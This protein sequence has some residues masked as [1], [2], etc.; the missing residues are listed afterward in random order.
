MTY[1]SVIL[2]FQLQLGTVYVRYHWYATHAPPLGTKVAV[3]ATLALSGGARVAHFTVLFLWLYNQKNIND[4]E[5]KHCIMRSDVCLCV[6]PNFKGLASIHPKAGHFFCKKVPLLPRSPL[7]HS[8][9][10]TGQGMYCREFTPRCSPRARKF[11]SLVNFFVRYT[12]AELRSVKV[13]QF[14][15]FSYFPHT[16]RLKSTFRW[17]AYSPGVTSQNDYDFSVW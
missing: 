4:C 2:P 5:L 8:E 17:P 13:A 16:K 3:P 11:P 15:D 14:S 12:V 9:Q 6:G 1:V 7:P 10:A